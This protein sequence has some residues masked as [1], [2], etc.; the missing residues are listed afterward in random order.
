[1]R[2]GPRGR[3]GRSD[4]RTMAE[5]DAA[6]AAD[7]RRATYDRLRQRRVRGNTRSPSDQLGFLPRVREHHLPTGWG[8]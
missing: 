1:M 3:L 2:A 5:R 4:P 6:S 7:W 8:G